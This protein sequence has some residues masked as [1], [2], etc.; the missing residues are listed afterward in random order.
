MSPGARL[1]ELIAKRKY[2]ATPGLTTP[3][4]AMIV[5][6]VGFETI[7]TGGYDVSLT[8]FGLP[9][10]G[11]ITATEMA[12]NARNIARS[13]KLPVI[14]DIDTGYGNALNVIRTVQDYEAAGV[15]AIHIEDQ[16]H[17]KKCGHVAGKELVSRQEAVG[18]LKAAIDSK[19]DKDFLIMGRT[20][21]IAAAG[22]GIDEAIAR[23]KAY[24]AAG[25]D[26]IWAEFPSAS[27]ELPKKFS[28]AMLKSFPDLPLYFNYSA[29]LNWAAHPA[30]FDE[31]AAL[32][33]RVIHVSLCGMR[34]TMQS[35]WDY[36]VDLKERG[37][38]AEI[39]FQKQLSKHPMGKFH[40]IAR[41][42]E[43]KALEE[44]Y[45]PDEQF[46]TKYDGAVGL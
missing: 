8:L 16:I 25:C 40:E 15:A 3:L 10:L 14:A 2:L 41:F 45:L 1:R 4:H 22:G 7:Y 37:S 18:K 27:M 31:L 34:T 26:M 43:F 24:A 17:P 30:S 6:R 11:L 38:Q 19:R 12:A 46:Q 13:V 9:D 35:M 36:A 23:G 39:D 29:N 5:E 28:E 21:A 42:P 44:K 32:G 33:Y 20:D